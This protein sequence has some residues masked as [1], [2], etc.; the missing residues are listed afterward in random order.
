M[1]AFLANPAV[2]GGVAPFIV[3]LIVVAVFAKAKLGGLAATAGFAV[4]VTLASGLAFTPLTAVRKV[5]LV[6]LLAPAV[7]MVLDFALKR[8]RA[9]MVVIALACGALAAWVFWSVLRQKAFGES[10]LLGGAAAVFVA[11]IVGSTLALAG[12]PVRAGAAALV[13]GLGTGVSAIL[14]AS[15]LLGIYGL[16]IGSGAAAFVLAQALTGRT[17]TAGA[18]LTLSASVAAGLVAAAALVLAQLPWYGLVVLGFIPLAVQ[19]PTPDR[20]PVWTQTLIACAYAL[21]VALVACLLTW[22]AQPPGSVPP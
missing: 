15:A 16:A 22:Q 13:L 7:G 2:Q 18:T 20:L 1:E 10:L 9:R 21:S 12:Q 8:S 3:G 17:I 19:L 6:G 5:V 11:W 14:G 4:A